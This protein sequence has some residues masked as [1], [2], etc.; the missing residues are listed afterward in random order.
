M[1]VVRFL[2]RCHCSLPKIVPRPWSSLADSRAACQLAGQVIPSV[3]QYGDRGTCI[4]PTTVTTTGATH[5]T[6]QLCSQSTAGSQAQAKSL[7][8][9]LGHH[10]LSGVQTKT[11]VTCGEDRRA[12]ASKD[13]SS[14]VLLV[15]CSKQ[16]HREGPQGSRVFSYPLC[17][18]RMFASLWFCT[19]ISANAR[20]APS[21]PPRRGPHSRGCLLHPLD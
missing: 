20:A 2:H 14:F 6:R 19:M 9:A 18:A 5:S 1:I 4:L 11:W 13:T 12:A 16:P 7:S 21:L 10:A 15:T 8:R 17:L 3:P